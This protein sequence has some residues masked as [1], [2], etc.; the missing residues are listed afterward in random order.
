[1]ESVRDPCSLPTNTALKPTAMSLQAQP[2]FLYHRLFCLRLAQVDDSDNEL[3]KIGVM[4]PMEDPSI[5][6]SIV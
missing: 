1:M 5:S 4:S 3:I 2:E 6:E